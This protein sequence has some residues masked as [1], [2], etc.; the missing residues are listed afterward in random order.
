MSSRPKTSSRT[1]LAIC[2]LNRTLF[3]KSITSWE[4]D[5]DILQGGSAQ[6]ITFLQTFLNN[7]HSATMRY[8]K[9]NFLYTGR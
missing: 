6:D 7:F 1:P 9:I 2:E 4:V 5:P 8:P 3:Y